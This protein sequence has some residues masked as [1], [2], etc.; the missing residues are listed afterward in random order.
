MNTQ[1]NAIEVKIKKNG[2]LEKRKNSGVWE[3]SYVGES[4]VGEGENGNGAGVT[5]VALLQHLLRAQHSHC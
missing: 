4:L 2:E 1:K 3:E 5:G